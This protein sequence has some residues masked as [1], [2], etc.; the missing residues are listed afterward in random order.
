MATFTP[1]VPQLTAFDSPVTRGLAKA[2]RNPV[3]RRGGLAGLSR[4]A[5]RPNHTGSPEARLGNRQPPNLV[6]TT[7]LTKPL[8]DQKGPGATSKTAESAETT[9][10]GGN[11]SMPGGAFTGGY[12]RG[13]QPPP[14]STTPTDGRFQTQGEGDD[15]PV[16]YDGYTYHPGTPL[17][18]GVG[19]YT[20]DGDVFR[21]GSGRQSGVRITTEEM[22]ERFP[23]SVDTGQ[24]EST[25]DG[26]YTPEQM[27]SMINRHVERMTERFG[28]QLSGDQIT[29]LARITAMLS[30]ARLTGN[31]AMEEE[32]TAL[33][34]RTLS[35]Y[36]GTGEGE[37]ENENGRTTD[38]GTSRGTGTHTST[39]GGHPTGIAPPAPTTSPD[40]LTTVDSEVNRIL[41]EDGVL[42]QTAANQGL[43]AAARRGFLGSNLAAGSSQLQMIRNALPMAQ[44]NARWQ[45]TRV[46]QS[47]SLRS[48]EYQTKLNNWARMG[49]ARLQS[50]TSLTLQDRA[51]L[52][53][54][55]ENAL[56]REFRTTER[57]AGQEYQTS[58]REGS[59]DFQSR[60]RG[61]DR[62]FTTSEREAGQDWR[63]SEREE[64][65][66]W[67]DL[68]REDTQEFSN[69][70]TGR[71]VMA[72]ISSSVAGQISS[73]PPG[74]SAAQY[75]AEVARIQ[76]WGAEQ[77]MI[78]SEMYGIDVPNWP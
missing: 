24:F 43:A 76:R 23:G 20:D 9:T 45:N 1:R 59:Q 39:T 46:I 64:S 65:Q 69:T 8:F 30:R 5:E 56:D 17:N 10:R 67:Q 66:G 34:E 32:Y 36:L 47:D 72:G 53:N 26:F 68:V 44:D 60:E 58:E 74:L 11:N 27:D 75:D 15:E 70:Q 51:N 21:D 33:Y 55:G 48:S 42:M 50:E 73:L 37:E 3:S 18:G 52:W 12:T 13:G 63:T 38:T 14:D 71:S 2:V 6:D 61:L 62:E 4:S 54:S 78:F 7:D 49:V 57:E 28:D 16:Q 77:F 22:S 29:G 19:F 25:D 35:E 41:Q 40:V 31:E